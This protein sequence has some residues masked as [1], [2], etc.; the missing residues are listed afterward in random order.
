MLQM[1]KQL[2]FAEEQTREYA[3]GQGGRIGY[4]DGSYKFMEL[5][6]QRL[7]KNIIEKEQKN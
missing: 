2:K 1:K 5:L 3:A 4:A 6:I 7:K